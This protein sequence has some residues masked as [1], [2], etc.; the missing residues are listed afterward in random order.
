MSQTINRPV[1]NPDPEAAAE[2][3]HTHSFDAE[4][5]RCWDCDCRPWGAI[6]TWPCGT[7]V[8]REDVSV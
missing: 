1:S 4:A 3:I 2:A 7:D 5:A 8:A 6:A